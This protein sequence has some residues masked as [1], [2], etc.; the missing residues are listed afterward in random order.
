LY[1]LKVLLN[2]KWE[3]DINMRKATLKDIATEIGCSVAVVSTVLNNAKGNSKVCDATRQK[4]IDYASKINYRPNFASRS[5]KMN[6]THTLGIYIQPRAWRGIG[7]TYDM[8]I[9][10]GIEQM[11]RKYNYE[12]LLLNM[13]GKVLPDICQERWDEQRI[14][15]LILI[16]A[17]VD[18]EW[19]IKLVK[20]NPYIVAIDYNKVTPNLSN[21]MFD[22]VKAIELA[23]KHLASLGHS[24]I[25]FIGHCVQKPD[26]DVAQR[27]KAFLDLRSKY[28]LDMHDELFYDI[29]KCPERISLD[30][31]YCQLEGKTGADYFKSLK[32]PPTAIICYNDLVAVATLSQFKKI[33]L[34]VPKDVSIVGFD[35]SEF[36]QFTSPTITTI[37]HP[38]EKMG[39]R[40]TEVLLDKIINKNQ[41]EVHEIFEP[42]LIIR[43]STTQNTVIP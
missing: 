5:L 35:N 34:S 3:Y 43:D 1:S 23:A 15:G 12:L 41:I 2:I 6:R 28:S 32:H 42:T 24:R 16:H 21:I 26:W 7:N 20:N 25:G 38:L 40:G 29:K 8:G 36:C 33:G 37:D 19:I 10:K 4:I 30:E 22:N 9:L 14:D 17:D 31:T 39:I 18:A 13:G 27:E 11:A